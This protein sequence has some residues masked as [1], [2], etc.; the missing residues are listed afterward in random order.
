MLELAEFQQRFSGAMSGGASTDPS[1]A[2]PAFAVYRNTS[3]KVLLDAL[4]ANYPTVAML[5]GG[6]LFETLAIRYIHAQPPRTPVLALYG[7][8]FPKFI[9]DQDVGREVPYIGDV[10]LLERFWTEAFF[11]P[12]APVFDWEAANALT[13]EEL[14][15]L[16]PRLHPAARLA[17]FDTPAVT[18]WMAHRRADDFEELAPDWCAE[19]ALVVRRGAAV[20]VEPIDQTT[21]AF[22]QQLRHGSSFGAAAEHL[23][24]LFDGANLEN[25]FM[26]ALSSVAL[27]LPASDGRE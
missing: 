15:T 2:S 26:T 12:D 7:E 5:I 10:A 23:G 18:I 9:A 20:V 14:L 8:E 13:P 19:G 16:R 27:T 6:D 1:F 4:D 17:W 21:Y 25:L 3:A 24:T 11:A 22:V